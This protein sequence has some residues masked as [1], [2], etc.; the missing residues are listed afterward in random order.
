TIITQGDI[1]EHDSV[2]SSHEKTD[3]T[4]SKQKMLEE[5]MGFYEDYL[6]QLQEGGKFKP[7][8]DE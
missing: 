1:L 4:L 5:T 2:A 8:T 6:K 3:L 7:K